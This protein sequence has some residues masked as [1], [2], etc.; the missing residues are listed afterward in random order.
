MPSHQRRSPY[1]KFVRYGAIMK[2][3]AAA[4]REV[5]GDAL[6]TTDGEDFAIA[7]LRERTRPKFHHVKALLL[8]DVLR[9]VPSWPAI[10]CG[11]PHTTVYGRLVSPPFGQG[12]D[13]GTPLYARWMEQFAQN[14]MFLNRAYTFHLRESADTSIVLGCVIV[15]TAWNPSGA[16]SGTKVDWSI[17]IP[18]DVIHWVC[19][20]GRGAVHR[21][22]FHPESPLAQ[23][24]NKVKGTIIHYGLWNEWRERDPPSR[25]GHANVTP[26]LTTS[27]TLPA[28]DSTPPHG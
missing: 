4:R 23:L 26:S 9:E 17:A 13:A 6:C 21:A 22:L 11:P 14:S 19:G 24:P 2:N 7:D 10:W 3:Y 27:T 25:H 16:E 12:W 5:L 15:H 1:A 20:G 8:R 28:I 18:R